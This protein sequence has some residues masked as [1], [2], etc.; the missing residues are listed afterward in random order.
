M[1][2]RYVVIC[3]HC[4]RW[5]GTELSQDMAEEYK[6]MHRTSAHPNGTDLEVL[7]CREV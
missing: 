7:V 5:I 4:G 6:S 3:Q 2:K 1:D